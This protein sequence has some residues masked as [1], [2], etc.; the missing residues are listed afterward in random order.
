MFTVNDLIDIAAKMEK[1]G[2][3]V[4]LASQKKVQNKTLTSLLQWMADEEAAHRD[5]FLD[6]KDEW[7][8]ASEQTDL[9]TMLPDVI[10]EMMGDKTLSLDEVDFSKIRSA[11]ALLETFIEFENDTLFF[12]AFLKAFIQDPQTLAGLEKII[13]EEKNHVEKLEE[14][15]QAIS[16]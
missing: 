11:S 3:A 10:R 2:E 8:P 9:E 16:R 6:Q 4:Y 15:V 7:C 5:W 13:Q 1:N 12:Y 14:M